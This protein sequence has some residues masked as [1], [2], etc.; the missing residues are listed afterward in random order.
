[1]LDLPRRPV[2]LASSIVII[3]SAT[4]IDPFLPFKFVPMKGRNAQTPVIHRRRCQ[5]II[6]DPL[7]PFAADPGTRGERQ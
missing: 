4:A 2:R 5:R 3:C 1:L 6:S 7:L